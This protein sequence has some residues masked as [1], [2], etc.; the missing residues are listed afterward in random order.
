MTYRRKGTPSDNQSYVPTGEIEHWAATNDP[1]D[2]YGKVLTATYGLLR[3]DLEAVDAAVQQ[4]VDAA[5]D[6][7]EQSPA[8][9]AREALMGVYQDRR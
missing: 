4:E 5:T 6:L 7:A 8:P 2:R 9:D 1:L 3:S